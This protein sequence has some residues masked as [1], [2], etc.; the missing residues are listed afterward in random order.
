MT[1]PERQQGPNTRRIGLD[2]YAMRAINRITQLTLE[3]LVVVARQQ[4]VI[5][6][7]AQQE[8]DR[9][10]KVLC[11]RSLERKGRKDYLKIPPK[12]PYRTVTDIKTKL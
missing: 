6:A 4:A 5:I 11:P 7:V 9:I 3:D 8:V 12:S 1:S 10:T 2:P